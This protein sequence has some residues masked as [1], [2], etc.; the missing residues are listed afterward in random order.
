MMKLL[1]QLDIRA[2]I[3]LIILFAFVGALIFH[4]SANLEKTLENILLVAIG[5]YLRDR[6]GPA[7]RP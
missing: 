7:G 2:T 6:T 1:A 3:T 4:Y 5:Y